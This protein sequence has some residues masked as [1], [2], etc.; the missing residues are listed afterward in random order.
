MIALE[1]DVQGIEVVRARIV[2]EEIGPPLRGYRLQRRA[3]KKL[4]EELSLDGENAP[5]SLIDR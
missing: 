4:I 3:E 5:A 2:D 1:I